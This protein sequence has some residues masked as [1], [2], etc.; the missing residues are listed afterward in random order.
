MVL[1]EALARYVMLC[2][3]AADGDSAL[4][5][6]M[7]TAKTYPVSMSDYWSICVQITLLVSLGVFASRC[8]MLL[9]QY[10]FV[11]IWMACCVCHM[12]LELAVL[13]VMYKCGRIGL[14]WWHCFG[15]QYHE[16]LNSVLLNVLPRLFERW[17][18]DVKP[19]SIYLSTLATPVCGL[20][21]LITSVHVY[22]LVLWRRV[23]IVLMLGQVCSMVIPCLLLGLIIWIWSTE[24][25]L[26]FYIVDYQILIAVK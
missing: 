20:L 19:C 2:Y 3:Y 23:W 6:L 17:W 25:W 22:V 12:M 8:S 11:S 4:R 5:M 24:K 26:G 16:L 9:V 18:W 15:P 1:K 7:D 13:L 14:C 10:Y 21:Q